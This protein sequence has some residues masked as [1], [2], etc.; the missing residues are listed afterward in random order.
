MPMMGID[1]LFHKMRYRFQ[2]GG[3]GDARFEVPLSTLIRIPH[4]NANNC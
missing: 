4:K 2:K 1:V 3:G